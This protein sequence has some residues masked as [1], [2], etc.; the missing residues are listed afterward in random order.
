MVLEVATYF[1]PTVGPPLSP[2]AMPRPLRFALQSVE[3]LEAVVPAA[4]PP[5]SAFEKAALGH[6]MP[7]LAATLVYRDPSLGP[8]EIP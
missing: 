7:Q 4:A 5:H 8:L 1:L 2:S 3:R 6:L